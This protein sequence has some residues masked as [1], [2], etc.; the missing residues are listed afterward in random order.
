MTLELW[1]AFLAATTVFL[2]IPGPTLLLVIGYA[3][4]YGRKPALSAVFGVALGDL[5][6]MTVSLVGLGAVLATSAGLFA[7][8]KW[9]GAAYLIY[10]GLKQWRRRAHVMDAIELAPASNRILIFNAFV[11]TALNPKSIM[12]FIAFLPHFIDPKLPALP[13]M[14]I[15]GATFWVL[16]ILTASAYA[17]MSGTLGMAFRSPRFRRN[18]DR[19]GASALIGAGVLTA[20]MQRF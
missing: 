8:L 6:A 4:S 2:L 9:L 1:L 7:L 3:L 13:Q 18:V 19:L 16:A 15:L 5:V 17:F 14:L 11:V 20:T 12:F 10:L